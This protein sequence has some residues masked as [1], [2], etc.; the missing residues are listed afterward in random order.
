MW[1]FFGGV[2]SSIF[3]GFMTAFDACSKSAVTSARVLIFRLKNG[4]VSTYRE[5]SLTSAVWA[6]EPLMDSPYVVLVLEGA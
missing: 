2:V 6:S 4:K 1:L 5:L 3:S